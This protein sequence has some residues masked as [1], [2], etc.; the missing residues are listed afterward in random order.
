VET[1]VE[2]VVV[3]VVVVLA[4]M[5]IEHL[6]VEAEGLQIHLVRTYTSIHHTFM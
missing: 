2:A 3:V 4:L 6:L 1:L 5:V